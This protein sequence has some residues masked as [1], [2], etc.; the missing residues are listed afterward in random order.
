MNKKILLFGIPILLLG[1]VA[2]AIVYTFTLNVNAY[3]SEPISGSG[4]NIDLSSAMVNQPYYNSFVIHNAATVSEPSSVTWF[5]DATYNTAFHYAQEVSVDGGSTYT[6]VTATPLTFDV[7]SGDTTVWI[8]TTFNTG[9]LSGD[10]IYGDVK[11]A[12]VLQA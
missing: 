8:K 12:G 5:P 3:V 11:V 9:S 2:A 10:R 1:I 7:N 4:A 6:D